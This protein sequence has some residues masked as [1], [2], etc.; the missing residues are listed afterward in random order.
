GNCDASCL[1]YVTLGRIAGPRF[2]HYQAAF[3]FGQI[4]FELVERRGL[5]RFQA[6]C[7]VYFASWI[8]RWMKHVRS[9]L[10]LL[11]RAFEVANRIGDLTFA[12][13][14]SVNL[15]VDLLF[16]GDPLSEVQREAELGL[17]FAQKER[18]GNVTDVTTTQL[19]LIRTLRGLTPKF[20]CFD[21]GQIEELTFERH[22]ADN[23]ALPMAECWYW[24]RKLQARYFAGDYE[25][26]L[27]ASSRAQRLLWT[28]AAFFEEA[29]YHFYSAL[30]RAAGYDSVRSE[31]RG[32]HL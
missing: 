21:S 12:A 3:R 19:S 13:F 18:W 10:D 6:S 4:G 26:A 24:V 17:A 7:Y 28:S 23:K 29:E 11:R 31:E 32:Q 22:L 15:R 8:G 9:N 27:E 30:S 25:E 16:A 5:K 2:G 1:A 20:G 14:A